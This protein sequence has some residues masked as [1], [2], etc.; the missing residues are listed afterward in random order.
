MWQVRQI[1]VHVKNMYKLDVEECVALRSKVEKVQSRNVDELCHM[2]L[3]YL[4]HGTLK[5]MQ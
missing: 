5:I 1:K 4:H 3:R 2:R